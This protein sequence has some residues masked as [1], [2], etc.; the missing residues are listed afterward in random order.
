MN[1][2]HQSSHLL[3]L[4]YG[5]T[6]KAGKSQRQNDQKSPLTNCG[7]CLLNLDWIENTKFKEMFARHYL[8]GA[9]QCRVLICSP[10]GLDQ[11]EGGDSEHDDGHI[12]PIH[13]T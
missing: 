2:Y 10:R 6:N 13:Q 5:A 11:G 7:R 8:A 1:F 4:C 9:L 3:I 12:L